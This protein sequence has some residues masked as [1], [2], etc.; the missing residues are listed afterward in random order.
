MYCLYLFWLWKSYEFTPC[1]FFFFGWIYKTKPLAFHY[2]V[3]KCATYYASTMRALTDTLWLLDCKTRLHREMKMRMKTMYALHNSTRESV[4]SCFLTCLY[5]I[6]YYNA[7]WYIPIC[8]CAIHKPSLGIQFVGK[9]RG[10]YVNNL[11]TEK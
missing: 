5:S 2:W 9:L 8:S 10:V 3:Y 7:D 11:A 1:V 4:W 6:N